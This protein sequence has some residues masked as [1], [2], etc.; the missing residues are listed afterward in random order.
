MQ[1][2]PFGHRHILPYNPIKGSMGTRDGRLPVGFTLIELLLVVMIVGILA[3]VA[4]PSFSTAAERA[5]VRSAQAT[6]NTIFEAERMYR[7]DQS[8]YGT[9]NDLTNQRYLNNPDSA[10]WTYANSNVA[11]ATFTMTAT[12]VGGGYNGNTVSID[13]T[14]DSTAPVYGGNHPLRNS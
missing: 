11:A 4:A 7:L 8:T 6:L 13:Q 12:R 14:F 1:F 10:E 5:R 2:K 9:L 3:A